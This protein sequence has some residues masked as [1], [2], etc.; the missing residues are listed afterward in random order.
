MPRSFGTDAVNVKEIA[1]KKHDHFITLRLQ[2]Q[3]FFSRRSTQITKLPAGNFRN[4]PRLAR[5]SFC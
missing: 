5:P 3:L 2:L 1:H 4:L